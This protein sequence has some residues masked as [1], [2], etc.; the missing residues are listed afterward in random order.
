MHLSISCAVLSAKIVLFKRY[1]FIMLYHI[2]LNDLSPLPLKFVPVV[3]YDLSYLGTNLAYFHYLTHFI[4]TQ[5]LPNF[6]A[7][8]QSN[9]ELALK[10]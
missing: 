7:I 9:I 1:I 4:K 5:L 10:T 8:C 6:C 2:F 3:S